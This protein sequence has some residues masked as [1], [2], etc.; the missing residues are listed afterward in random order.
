[1]RDRKRQSLNE[2]STHCIDARQLLR[3]VHHEG[4]KQL[5][6]VHRGADL[7]ENTEKQKQN[8]VQI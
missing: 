4:N 1:M 2:F 8:K 5:L 3:E 7:Q 6:S